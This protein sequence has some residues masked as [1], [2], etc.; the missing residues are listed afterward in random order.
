MSHG[1]GGESEKWQ[2]SVTYYLN[3][4]FRSNLVDLTRQAR[5]KSTLLGLCH[6]RVFL[7]LQIG[8]LRLRKLKF[9][10]YSF[11]Q[12]FSKWAN[13][14]SCVLQI[15]YIVPIAN[16][17]QRHDTDWWYSWLFNNLKLAIDKE[18]FGIYIF[19]KRLANGPTVQF[20][21]FRCKS[22]TWKA[23]LNSIR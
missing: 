14:P 12:K 17:Q 20:V 1:G 22:S 11:C 3:G 10:K 2:K 18:V 4:S 16:L 13:N 8:P 9:L 7:F 15:Q 19:I 21:F 23:K 5:Q 6:T